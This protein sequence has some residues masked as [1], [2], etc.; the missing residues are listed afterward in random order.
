M[1]AIP[2]QRA[3]RQ[4]CPCNVRTWDVQYW[5]RLSPGVAGEP[6]ASSSFNR[7]RAGLD[8]QIEDTGT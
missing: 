7:A 3:V 1:N 5:N 2:I 4:Y 6:G 8:G